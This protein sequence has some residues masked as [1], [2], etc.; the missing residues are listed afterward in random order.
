[1]EFT[2]TRNDDEDHLY[3]VFARK[4]D[5]SVEETPCARVKLSGLG[6]A[7]DTMDLD[8]DGHHELIARSF[9]LPSGITQASGSPD[10]VARN[11]GRVARRAAQCSA[12]TDRLRSG[13]GRSV[14]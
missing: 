10:R 3:L 1:V 7:Y 11:C 12:H 6:V 8:G 5:G 9:D 14:R 2:V 4:D 13:S